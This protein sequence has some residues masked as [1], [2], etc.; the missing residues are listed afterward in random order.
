MSGRLLAYLH[1]AVTQRALQSDLKKGLS[2]LE[3]IAV[4]R[5]GDFERL[6]KE[7]TDAVLALPAVLS[8]YNLS[9]SLQGQRDGSSEE[10][11]ALVAVGSPP[12]PSQVGTVGAINLLGRD[13]TNGFVKNLVGA[14]PKIERVSKFEDLLP[15]LQMQRA[16]AVLLPARLFPELKSASKLALFAH[17]LAKGVGLPA[18]ASVTRAGTELLHA[19]SRMPADVAKLL[20][21]DQWR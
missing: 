9:P 4:G 2:G 10:R 15:L 3:V 14:S 8:A 19:V 1:V 7:G 16:D 11:Y 12:V 13:G 21:V 17:E 5:V 20:G 6:L 18:G